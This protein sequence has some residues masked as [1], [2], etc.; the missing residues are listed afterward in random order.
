MSRKIPPRISRRDRLCSVHGNRLDVILCQLDGEIFR[1]QLP[2]A[3]RAVG[4]LIVL[5]IAHI[6]D[7]HEYAK[8]R[9]VN[10][11]IVED[12]AAVTKLEK[13]SQPD[14]ANPALDS[15]ERRLLADCP[16]FKVWKLNVDGAFGGNATEESFVSLLIMDGE[17]SLECCGKTLEL[18]KGDSL[19]IPANA[20]QYKLCGK[21]EIIET[22]I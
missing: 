16:L 9:F 22:R 6:V 21:L 5:N 13:Y 11:D 3:K 8:C 17:G 19:F 10:N 12:G 7:I 2:D 4:G 1:G 20:G 15:D 18:K 14:F